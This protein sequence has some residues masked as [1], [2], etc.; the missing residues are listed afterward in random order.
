MKTS[1]HKDLGSG[2]WHSSLMTTYSVDPAFYD[3][4]IER[5]LRRHGCENNLLLADAAML[6]RA[7]QATPNAFGLAGRRYAL[8]PVN[9][10]GCFHPKIHLRLG[11][12]SARLVVGSANATA[13]GWSRNLEV[14]ADIDWQRRDEN[15]AL[16]PLIRKSYDYLMHWLAKLPGEAIQYKCRLHVRD[17]PWLR[18]IEANDHEIE[19]PD[20]SAVDL[21]CERGGDAPSILRKLVE[22]TDG[23]KVR[24]IVIVSPYWDSNLRGLYELRKRLPDCR[25]LVVLN[26]KKNAFP[27]SA[28]RSKDDVHFVELKTGTS[29]NRFPHAKIILIETTTADHVVFGSANCSDDALGLWSGVARNAEVSVYRRL[30][31]GAV[32]SLLHMDVRSK[33]KRDAIQNPAPQVSTLEGKQGPFTPGYIEL[34]NRELTWYP[35]PGVE[36][37]GAAI[38]IGDLEVHPLV[39]GG[40]WRAELPSLPRGTLIAFVILKTGAISAPTIV[41]EEIALR[42]AAPGHVD[43]RLRE[44]FDRI[45]EGKEDLL[46]LAQHAHMIFAPDPQMDV[47]KSA[48]R[49]NHGGSRAE[50]SAKE[51]ATAE[52]F[53]KAISL[54]PATGGTGRFSVDDPGLLQVLSIVMR[55]IAG[56][57]TAVNQESIEDEDDRVLVEADTDDD[58]VSA[59]E[60]QND[61]GK[62]SP[63]QLSRLTSRYFS[64]DQIKR[65]R[66]K[67]VRAMDAFEAL[68]SR[69]RDQPALISNRLAAQTAFMIHLM[70]LACS[71][72]HKRAEGD[73]IRLMVLYPTHDSE[74]EVSFALRIAR[75]LRDIWIG[76]TDDSIARHIFIDEHHK[77]LPDDMVAWIVLSRWAIA[78]A[79]LAGKR[80]DNLA[81]RIANIARKL[82]AAT[83]SIGPI[84]AQAEA[85]MLRELD[86]RMGVAP[87]DT[88]ELILYVRRVHETDT[89]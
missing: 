37:A 77:A 10:Q 67:L 64:D 30:K 51:F 24:R 36:P 41:H 28:L 20:G 25:T 70:M 33:L 13:A 40:L 59:D 76:R 84:D 79:Y 62:P 17:S 12:D 74:R 5:R 73:D 58:D 75:M 15:Q 1:L 14:I 39:T 54:A 19:L 81:S 48:R 18:D 60:A 32:L 23:E 7:A 50:R 49:A 52:D 87:T 46:D 55:G 31:P 57:G 43:R 56:I 22:H 78:R 83:T 6:T 45:R 26:P 82:F 69:L 86:G 72:V 35:A 42:N 38:R 53:R 65:R 71:F 21:L 27:V 9:T 61:P 85:R 66:S 8:V 80:T 68:L 63:P 44:A 3:A 4:Y 89:A 2:G 16:G 11:S 88:D 29:S 47:R 34:A